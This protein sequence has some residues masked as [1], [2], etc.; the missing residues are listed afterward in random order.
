MVLVLNPKGKLYGTVN[1]FL[2]KGRNW[3]D[4][5]FL[6]SLIN[7][8]A[9]AMQRRRAETDLEESERKYRKIFEN[10]QDVFY[11]T[12]VNG[13]IIEISPSIERYSGFS[14]DYLIGKQV[15][16]VYTKS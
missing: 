14:R 13:K 5:E 1:I 9:V 8:F 15:E 12:D 3:E 16:T 6:Q 7:L 2:K 4:E 11:Q 10:V